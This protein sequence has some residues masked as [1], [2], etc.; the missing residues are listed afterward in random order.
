MY[1]VL[2]R[3]EHLELRELQPTDTD[4]VFAIYG[5]ELATAHLSFEPRTRNEVRDL[6]SRARTSARTEYV[7]AITD[8]TTL[9]G[10]GRLATDPHQPRA[11]TLGFTLNP[12]S[13]GT[14]LGTETARLL[15][16]PAFEDARPVNAA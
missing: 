1:P 7:L 16:A 12:T 10:V 8:A 5:S 2:R 15:L 14:G 3:G 9:I 4:A 6:L 11:A 13:W